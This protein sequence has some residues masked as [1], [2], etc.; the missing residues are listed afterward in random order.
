[1]KEEGFDKSVKTK[2][3]FDPASSMKCHCELRAPS[4]EIYFFGKHWRIFDQGSFA[5]IYLVV[6]V[7]LP[8]PLF[9]SHPR[10]AFFIPLQ[11]R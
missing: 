8:P 9:F 7:L 10:P 4:R 6:F 11:G 1:M 3:Y 2:I 5:L